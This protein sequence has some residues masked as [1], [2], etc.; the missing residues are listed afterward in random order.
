MN[1]KTPSTLEVLKPNL[2]P[3]HGL[4]GGDRIHWVLPAH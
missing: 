1:S 3:Q 2:V 4:K